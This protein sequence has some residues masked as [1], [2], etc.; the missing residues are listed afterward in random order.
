[1]ECRT[2]YNKNEATGTCDDIDECAGSNT[3]CAEDFVCKNNAGGHT[4]VC[5]SPKT[6]VDGKCVLVA[7]E[8]KKT[9]KVVVTNDDEDEDSI[10][11]NGDG[12]NK[13][14]KKQ[15]CGACKAIGKK[16]EEVRSFSSFC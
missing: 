6:V 10:V 7:K 5:P 16:F 15:V 11:I 13:K 9:K 2:G 12:T 1:M 3:L 8:K 14:K 4:C